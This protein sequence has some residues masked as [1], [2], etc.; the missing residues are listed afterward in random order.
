MK[1]CMAL[2]QQGFTTIKKR[3][4]R[5]VSFEQARITNAIFRAMQVCGEGDML[6]DPARI[7][8]RVLEVLYK[9]YPT[10]HVP[11]VEEIQDVVEE[12]LILMDFAKTAKHY[13]LYRAEHAKIREKSRLVRSE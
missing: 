10:S 6:H 4:G 9:R 1:K 12:T 5:I 3:D 7:S 13:I 2:P 11:E 8:E